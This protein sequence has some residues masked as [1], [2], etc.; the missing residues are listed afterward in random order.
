[1]IVILSNFF[2][3]CNHPFIVL[4]IPTSSW[5]WH[6]GRSHTKLH[7]SGPRKCCSW[8]Y[9]SHQQGKHNSSA[10]L[11]P[12]GGHRSC[13]GFGHSCRGDCSG[14]LVQLRSH[15]HPS[16]CLK[17]HTKI[18]LT[19]I[20]SGV[21]DS[22]LIGEARYFYIILSYSGHFDACSA[23]KEKKTTLLWNM[24]VL[25]EAQSLHCAQNTHGPSQLALPLNVTKNNILVS[26]F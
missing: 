23:P 21:A 18:S 20:I 16:L 9:S 2:I 6:L 8:S 12:L 11:C 4:I 13:W 1:M 7:P 26:G 22:L 10:S 17:V 3:K 15:W 19:L 14:P 25:R 5:F 24:T